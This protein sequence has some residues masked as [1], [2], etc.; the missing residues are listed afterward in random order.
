MEFLYRTIHRTKAPI[1]ANFLVLI[2]YPN[3]NLGHDTFNRLQ[4]FSYLSMNQDTPD[5]GKA[6]KEAKPDNNEFYGH[7]ERA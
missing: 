1:E 4:L 3:Q 2:N 7:I 5:T 6:A